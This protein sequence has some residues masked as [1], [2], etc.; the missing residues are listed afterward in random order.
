MKVLRDDGQE[1]GGVRHRERGEGGV[2]G[3]RQGQG[4]VHL[5]TGAQDDIRRPPGEAH[6]PG[7]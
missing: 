2:Q 1:D 4:R 5:E 7:D 3:V 6:P